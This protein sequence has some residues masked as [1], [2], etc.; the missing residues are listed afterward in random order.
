MAL[1]KG[2]FPGGQV[3]PGA[4]EE[5]SR[6]IQR[7]LILIQMRRYLRFFWIGATIITMIKSLIGGHDSLSMTIIGGIFMGAIS[8]GITVWLFVYVLANWV[9]KTFLYFKSLFGGEARL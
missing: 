7:G 5:Q 2:N 3:P 4:T 8:Y 6:E 1:T 9:I